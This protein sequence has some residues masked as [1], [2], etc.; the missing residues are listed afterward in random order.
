LVW[1]V[2]SEK[3]LW[4]NNFQS[5]QVDGITQRLTVADT[6]PAGAAAAAAAAA[7]TKRIKLACAVY[8]Q[9]LYF[10]A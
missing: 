2:L 10:D 1:L 5:P 3:H 6:T 4:N 8:R 7:A 9:G